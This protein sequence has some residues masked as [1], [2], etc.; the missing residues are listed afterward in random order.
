[1]TEKANESAIRAI[2]P[3]IGQTCGLCGEMKPIPSDGKLDAILAT[4]PAE[5]AAAGNDPDAQE[6]ER[7]RIHGPDVRTIDAL[8]SALERK[9]AAERDFIQVHKN[10]IQARGRV[11]E[12]ELEREAGY[13]D[14]AFVPRQTTWQP[15]GAAAGSVTVPMDVRDMPAVLAFDSFLNEPPEYE[16]R[17]RVRDYRHQAWPKWE[18]VMHEIRALISA[19]PQSTPPEEGTTKFVRDLAEHGIRFDLNPT[20][21]WGGENSE[22]ELQSLGN[23][24]LDYIKRIDESMRER[25]KDALDMNRGGKS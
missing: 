23:A 5:R 6:L 16:D 14:T 12:L 13:S 3:A 19:A 20:V 18:K 9:D 15:A 11:A 4:P 22:D 2:P 1:M 21:Q 24:Y 10:C 17:F 8:R 25:A 7:A